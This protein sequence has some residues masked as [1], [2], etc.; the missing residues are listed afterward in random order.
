MVQSILFIN[1]YQPK[2][3]PLSR[4]LNFSLLDPKINIVICATINLLVMAIK[5]Y[6][7]KLVL[8]IQIYRVRYECALTLKPPDSPPHLH[9]KRGH[10]TSCRERRTY[11]GLNV[12]CRRMNSPLHQLCL[13]V[14]LYSVPMTAMTPPTHAIIHIPNHTDS[15]FD[16]SSNR[17]S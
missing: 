16:L 12:T 3:N 13:P 14:C 1:N 15:S 2:R 5:I 17:P 6:K 9:I 4:I 8:L 11:R 7:Y 10:P